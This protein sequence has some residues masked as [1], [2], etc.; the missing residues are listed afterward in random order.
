[1]SNSLVKSRSDSLLNSST[2]SNYSSTYCYYWPPAACLPAA[3]FAG[4][5]DWAGFL[6]PAF[7]YGTS[8]L[9]WS[10]I[11]SVGSFFLEFMIGSE[12]FEFKYYWLI[13]SPYS[14]IKSH[15]SVQLSFIISIASFFYGY[16]W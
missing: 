2:S 4:G 6:A 13:S 7:P 1:M 12:I 3:G 15:R 10:K 8:D 14:L 16:P 5:F 11:C 9:Y